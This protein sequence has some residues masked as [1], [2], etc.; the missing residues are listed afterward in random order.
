MLE[1][2]VFLG[3]RQKF[4]DI[5][6]FKEINECDFIVKQ[7]DK[8]THAIQVCYDLNEENKNREISG[9]LSSLKKFDLKEGFILTFNQKDDFLIDNK[10]IIVKPVWGWLLE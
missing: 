3:L 5:F 8:I 10:K 7:K 9:L 6:Y 1:N 2:V 4:R